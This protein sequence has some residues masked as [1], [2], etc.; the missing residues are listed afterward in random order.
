MKGRT[1]MDYLQFMDRMLRSNRMEYGQV[2]YLVTGAD[3][4][5]RDYVFHDI[6]G[7]CRI[8]GKTLYVI[9]DTG[10]RDVV[11]RGILQDAGYRLQNGL[12]G[13][14]CLYSP[15]HIRSVR[16]TS[17]LRR[18][19]G[20]LGYD[21]RQ[22]AKLLAYFHFLT[23]LETLASCVD[24]NRTGKDVRAGGEGA[25]TGPE[26]LSEEILCDYSS[27]YAVEERI[28]EIVDAGIIDEPERMHLLSKYAEVS[29]AAAD[30][31]DMLF[32]LMPF[33]QGKSIHEDASPER[34]LVFP[35]GELGEDETVR[36]V[37]LQLLRFGL[38]EGDFSRLAVLVFD[39]GYGQRQSLFTFLSSLSAAMEVHVFSDDF[40]TLS[41]EAGIASML[42]RFSARIYSRHLT[43][44][45][46]RRIE[47]ACGEI[48]MVK[49]AKTITYDRR[50]FANKPWDILFGT[51]KTEAYVQEAPVREPRYR[52]EMICRFSPGSGIIDFMGHTTMFVI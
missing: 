48:D 6:V 40:F 47:E 35:T 1:E 17:R 51:N 41:D 38:E 33:T 2:R 10:G 7:R 24:R 8:Q 32:V 44:E 42:N 29:S 50:V 30:F 25:K 23:H 20:T 16:G 9:D 52:K 27:V 22:K 28:Q 34:A 14:L 15:F 31:E 19:L 18:I 5:V 37:L 13:G 12:S 21:E 11:N 3:L 43:M 46:C 36:T 26:E 4:V 49:N 45:S 39:K